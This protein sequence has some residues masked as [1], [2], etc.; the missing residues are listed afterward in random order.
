MPFT[1]NILVYW[2]LIIS[3]F[4]KANISITKVFALQMFI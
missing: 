3:S 4:S 2:V 1:Y